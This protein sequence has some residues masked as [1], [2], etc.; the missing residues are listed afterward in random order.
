MANIYEVE[1][2][3]VIEDNFKNLM[4]KIKEED[5]K[6]VDENVEEDTYYTDPEEEFIRNKTCL[7]TRK[8]N[9]EKLELTYKPASTQRTEIYGKKESN[10]SIDVKDYKDIQF[11]I[12][13]LGYVEYVSFKKHRKTYTKTIDGIVHNIMLD[14]IDGVGQY[15]E[16]EILVH[17]AEEQ[18]KSRKE[19]DEFIKRMGCENLK[20][21]NIPYRDVVKAARK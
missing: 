19:L 21:R 3:Y 4:K 5:F 15:V 16:L 9:E 1:E 18:E 8:T 12:N 13:Q 17:T 11:I 10:V 7:R 6:F 2:S 14:T 20:V